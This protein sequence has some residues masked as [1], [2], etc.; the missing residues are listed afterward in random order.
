MI[1]TTDLLLRWFSLMRKETE[2]FTYALEF[3]IYEG[4]FY[5]GRLG[6]YNPKTHYLTTSDGRNIY[7]PA[8]YVDKVGRLLFNL[9]KCD[10]DN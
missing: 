5:S 1:T 3:A 8:E 9:T 7:I 4:R 2:F 10:Y 6:D